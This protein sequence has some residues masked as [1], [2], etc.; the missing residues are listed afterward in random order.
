MPKKNLTDRTIKTLK[1]AKPEKHYDL[2]DSVVPGFG[3]RVSETGRRTFILIARYP[4]S[5]NPTRRALGEYGAITL[6]K[7]REKARHWL[8]L[9]RKGIDPRDQEERERAA[10]Q[11]KRKNTFAAIAEDFITEK[12]PSE[13][14]GKE[15]E[16]DIRNNFMP[17][18]GALPAADI[19][20][21]Q[22][23]A[24]IRAKARKA[25]TQ[26]RNLLGTAK[27][28]F[29]WA[30]DQRAYGIKTSPAAQLKPTALCGEKVS[31][32]R[33]LSDVEL[34]ALWRAA[35]RTAYPYSPAY[36]TLVLT[37]LRLNEAA[38]AARGEMDF[39][40]RAWTIPAARMKGK[41]GKARPHVVP[42]TDDMLAILDRLPKFKTG[43]YLFSTTFGAS[44][45]WMS[46]KVKKRIDARMLRTLRA[47][48]RRRGDDPAK[49]EL[50]H[51]TNHDIRRTVRSG[52]SRL[53]I[54]E[55][56]REAVMAHVRPGI[57]GTY[58]L[59]DYLDEKREALELWAARL[60]S[61]VEPPPANVVE[62]AKARA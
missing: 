7:A 36:Q 41:N 22:I 4:G 28:L 39:A 53:K 54:S 47:L 10:E 52:L 37:A 34:F 25:P 24:L 49:V 46:D 17:A 45:V 40:N 48:A 51:W 50:A 16:R 3:V 9:L 29:Q 56:A 12:L 38:D 32:D 18:W 31:G 13:R 57:K 1:P 5:D 6:E 30:I 35:E 8:E 58:D 55:E 19:S 59:Y 2:M 27:R 62:L 43:D 33:I 42:L 61:I 15:V 23:A 14:K 20:E 11:Q 44:P 26:A 60:R 21:D